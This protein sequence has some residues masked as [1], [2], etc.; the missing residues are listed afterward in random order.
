M[1]RL[2]G[3][4]ALMLYSETPNIHMHTLKVAVIDASNHP[5]DYTFELFQRTLGRRLHLLEPLRYQLVDMPFKLHRP[6]WLENARI[7]L[8][9]HVRRARVAAPGGRRELDTLIGEITASPLDRTRPLWEFHF[10]EGM[11]DN[12]FAVIGKVHHALADG[13]ASANLMARAIDTRSTSRSE[14]DNDGGSVPPSTGVLLRAAARDHL[15]QIRELPALITSTVNGITRVR[16]RSRE[17]DHNATMAKNFRPPPT[18]LNHLVPPGRTFASAT[19]SLADVKATSK[20]FGVTINDLVLAT[21]AGALRE[22][23][24]RYDGRA[25]E[26]IIASVPAS[27]DTSPDRIVGNQL[28]AM[29]VSLPV[30]LDDPVERVTLSHAAAGIAKENFHLLGPAIM[31]RWSAYLPP[32]VAP[33]AFAWLARHEAQNMLMNVPISNVPGPRERGTIAGAPMTEI[34]SVGPVMNG[35]AMNM[36]VWSYVDQFNISVIADDHTFADTHEVTDAMTRSFAEIRSAAGLSG[37]LTAV[38]TAMA[39]VT[40]DAQ[41]H[42]R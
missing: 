21:A 25:A 34:Y 30:H 37:A 19:L 13:V 24:L 1:K 7:D 22:L 31:S 42:P 27:L 35:S 9:Y 23:L 38:G 39:H 29:L 14:C 4:D 26:P 36:T 32:P 11:A 17:R 2:N 3:W 5:G 10:V 16:R 12:R 8:D 41:R 6:M 40:P 20:H 15:D 28:G 33:R 18:F